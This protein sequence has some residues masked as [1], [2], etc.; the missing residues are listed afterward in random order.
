[1]NKKK[2]KKVDNI[3]VAG[4]VIN[5]LIVLLELIGLVICFSIHGLEIFEYYTVDSNLLLLLSSGFLVYTNACKLLGKDAFNIKWFAPFRYVSV[6]STIVTFFVVLTVLAPH[7]G[8]KAMFIEDAFVF[9]HLL[10]PLLAAVCFVFLEKYEF[11]VM[12]SLRALYF[13]FVYGAVLILLNVL[14]VVNGP[15]EFFKVYE[16]NVFVSIF[17]FVALI[18]AAYIFSTILR[19][20]NKKLC[21]VK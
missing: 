5:S 6:L 1:M 13:T 2:T 8:F 3:V 14:K 16:Q 17:W 4:L 12:D 20:L 7:D 9:Y 10:C 15:Y 18:G 19:H 21:I 11:K